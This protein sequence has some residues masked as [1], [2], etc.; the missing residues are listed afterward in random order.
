ME[1]ANFEKTMADCGTSMASTF[2]KFNLH[3]PSTCGSILD[4]MQNGRR[5]GLDKPFLLDNCDIQWY[6]PSEACEVLANAGQVLILGDSFMR[7]FTNGMFVVLNGNYQDGALGYHL[8]S[9][10]YTEEEALRWCSCENQFTVSALQCTPMLVKQPTVT[11]EPQLGLFALHVLSCS[12]T[13]WARF[14]ASCS[15][16]TDY[17]GH[18]VAGLRFCFVLSSAMN[19]HADCGV[20]QLDCSPY[21]MSITFRL[22]TVTDITCPPFAHT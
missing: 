10:I 1:F 17:H 13:L 16:D 3:K 2:P 18:A 12:S 15:W 5:A 4:E 8:N 21:P 6:T 7:H 9:R 11:K 19:I 20:H 14:Q 22:T